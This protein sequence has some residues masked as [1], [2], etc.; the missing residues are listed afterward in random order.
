M[1]RATIRTRPRELDE[2]DASVDVVSLALHAQNCSLPAL[3][4]VRA[5][6]QVHRHFWNLDELAVGARSE[7][8]VVDETELLGIVHYGSRLIREKVKKL[9]VKYP[10]K[11]F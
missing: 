3:Y 5:E 8:T 6:L 11:E 2:I 7:S 9:A 4:L 10:S 1:P